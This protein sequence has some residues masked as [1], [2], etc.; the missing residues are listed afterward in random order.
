VEQGQDFGARLFAALSGLMGDKG[1]RD[2]L[3][4]PEPN[5]AVEECLR[6][7]DGP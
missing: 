7:M 3:S 2:A 4:K 6:D 1:R 5:T